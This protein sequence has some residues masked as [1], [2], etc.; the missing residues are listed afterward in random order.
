MGLV[1]QWRRI[2]AELPPDWEEARLAVT[3][4]HPDQRSRAA[5]LLAPASP[6]RSGDE[7]RF[8]VYR[9]GAGVGPERVETLLGKL[10]EER[11]RGS[12]RL[13]EAA[14]RQ[15]REEAPR[16]SLATA[17]AAALDTLPAD[18][19]DL[20]GE[21]ALT[22][23]DHLDWAAL[24]LAPVNPTR[25]PDRTALRF[26]GARLAGYGASPEMTARCL[27]RLD[28]AGIPGRLNVLHVL[29]DTDNV[30]TQGPVWRVAGRAV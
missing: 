13:L 11:L 17:W 23:T 18:W 1:E 15:P 30:A 14:E 2:R 22:S 10:D 8:S 24:L 5:A 3:V 20:Y 25:V 21:V 26:R 9:S 19:S 7:L 4:P 12:I 28:E 6:G 27:A 16:E 29:S